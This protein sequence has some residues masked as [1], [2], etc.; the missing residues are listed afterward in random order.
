ME[1]WGEYATTTISSLQVLGDETGGFCICN[2]N[3]IIPGLKRID[4]ETSDYYM[5]AYNTNNPDPNKV[6][7]FIKIEVT[8]PGVDDLIYKSDYKL[9]RP[10]K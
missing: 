9:K 4:S 1:E 2:T 10:S 3:S 6:Q 8:R 5:L 7:R